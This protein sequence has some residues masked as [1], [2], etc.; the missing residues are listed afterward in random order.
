MRVILAVMVSLSLY[1]NI[2][3]LRRDKIE[4][5]SFTAATAPP[6]ALR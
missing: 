3:R 1:A 4:T 6:A 2:Q 5:V